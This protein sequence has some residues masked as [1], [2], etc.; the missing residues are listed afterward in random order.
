MFTVHTEGHDEGPYNHVNAGHVAPHLQKKT[1]LL[2]FK[3]G[4]RYPLLNKLFKVFSCYAC[5]LSQYQIYSLT[6]FTGICKD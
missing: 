5:L 2:S 1:F 3:Q 6:L 4:L